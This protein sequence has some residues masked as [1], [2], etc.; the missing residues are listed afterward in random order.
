MTGFVPD[1]A[2]AWSA[3]GCTYEAARALAESDHEA[4]LRAAFAGFDRFGAVPAAG[5]VAGVL[6]ERGVT[7]VPRGARLTTRSNLAGL[8]PREMDVLALIVDGMT[9]EGIAGKL[10]LSAKTIEHH[11][12]AIY[13]N[14]GVSGRVAATSFAHER[15]LF[16]QSP[17]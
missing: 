15:Q 6:R 16:Q 9:N 17:K 4:D 13:A 2:A 5:A 3:L 1:V 14:L 8:T 11:A 10:F 12:S 7:A